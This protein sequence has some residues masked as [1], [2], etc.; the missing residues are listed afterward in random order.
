MSLNKAQFEQYNPIVKAVKAQFEQYSPM[1]K[2]VKDTQELSENNLINSNGQLEEMTR[3]EKRTHLIQLANTERYIAA[4]AAIVAER[5]RKNA[6]QTKERDLE[7]KEQMDKQAFIS[8][9]INE[10]QIEFYK[11]EYQKR[12]DE[13]KLH[14]D[15][16]LKE[17]LK[18][19]ADRFLGEEKYL[20][21]LYKYIDGMNLSRESN[22]LENIEDE[23][24]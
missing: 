13:S 7:I 21:D 3:E 14:I 1:V 19:T 11:D 15:K 22:I 17:H 24:S 6:Q 4:R 18:L 12:L 10:F 20:K 9:F 23:I 16:E 2:D 8:K 5:S